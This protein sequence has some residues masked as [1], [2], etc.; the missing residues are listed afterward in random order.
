MNKSKRKM[1]RFRQSTYAY[2][3]I[4]PG[5]ILVM[6]ILVY[7]L[8]RGIVSSFFT[9]APASMKFA[10]FAGLDYYKDL[11]KDDIFAK[12]LKNSAI[13]TV[14][15][16]AAQYIIGLGIALILN[17]DFKG[18]GIYRSLILIPW[19]VPNIAAA[20]T[21][22][23]MYAGQY[24]IINFILKNLGIIA[25]D[26]D[27]LGSS[28][29]AF[30]ALIVTAVW[31]GI[32]FI[33]IVL[34]AALQSIDTSQYEAVRIDGGSPLQG[35]RHITLPGIKEVSITTVLLVT[36]WTFNQFDL[37]YAMTKGG[38]SNSTQ[39]VPVYTYMTAF[40]F[41]NLNSAAAIGVVGLLIVGV[42][43]VMYILHGRKGEKAL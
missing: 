37:V 5:L 9:Q 3:L 41:F 27:W 43:A 19:V 35:F 11:L 6:L 28:K 18:R 38:P 24:G 40:N 32:P 7:P 31:K 21:W 22:K 15:I 4:A 2:I 33:T 8:L 34:L 23:W 29:T 1:I 14:T 26:V 10:S 13:W 12:A 30:G 20:M 42:F 39:I 36:I 16:V 17:K 25:K